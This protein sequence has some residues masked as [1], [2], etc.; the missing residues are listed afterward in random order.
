MAEKTTKKVTAKKTVAKKTVSKPAMAKNR[1]QRKPLQKK[2]QKLKRQ[3]PHQWLI[4]SHVA[5]TRVVHVAV[6]ARAQKR[7]AHLVVS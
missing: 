3:W 4:N 6:N 5:A 2:S 1:S 7:N